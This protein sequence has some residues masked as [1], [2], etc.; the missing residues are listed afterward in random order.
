MK[1]RVNRGLGL[2]LG[3]IVVAVGCLHCG[4]RPISADSQAGVAHMVRLNGMALRYLE[5]GSDPALLV[6]ASMCSG[7]GVLAREGAPM[8]GDAG[9]CPQ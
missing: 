4:S 3:A 2:V 8:G 1:R 5:A 9:G 6:T 7:R